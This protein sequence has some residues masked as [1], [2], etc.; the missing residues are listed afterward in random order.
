MGLVL[1]GF[2]DFC[3]DGFMRHCVHA[4]Q[5]YLQDAACECVR[6]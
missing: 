1:I 3:P 4:I 6:R 2:V 5:G